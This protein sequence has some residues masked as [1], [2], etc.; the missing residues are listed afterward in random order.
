MKITIVAA[1]EIDERKAYSC[2]NVEWGMWRVT[3]F[4]HDCDGPAAR[5]GMYVRI[6]IQHY[7]SS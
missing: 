7:I 2:L 3:Y 1:Y 5:G 4:V 6:Y